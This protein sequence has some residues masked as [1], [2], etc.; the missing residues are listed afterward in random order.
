MSLAVR[1]MRLQSLSGMVRNAC[2]NE[3][4]TRVVAAFLAIT[5]LT[6]CSQVLLQKHTLYAVKEGRPLS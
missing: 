6:S 2:D 5:E 4:I 1:V 3:G